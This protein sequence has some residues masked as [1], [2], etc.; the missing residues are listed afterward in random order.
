MC[1]HMYIYEC[2]YIYVYIYIHV[3]IYTYTHTYIY[4]LYILNAPALTSWPAQHP[5]KKKITSMLHLSLKGYALRTCIFLFFARL[6]T[7]CVF[8]TCIYFFF[9]PPHFPA[10]LQ[11]HTHVYGAREE[12]PGPTPD[13]SNFLPFPNNDI[14]PLQVYVFFNF[15]PCFFS[16]STIIPPPSPR[17]SRYGL[18][19]LFVSSGCVTLWGGGDGVLCVGVGRQRLFVRISTFAP[20]KQVNYWVL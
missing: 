11:V 19:P 4:T 6:R 3:C 20:V 2:I 9:F 15:P 12:P 8:L 5:L 16:P 1:M 18:L 10:I 14:L 17:A 7:P 13:A